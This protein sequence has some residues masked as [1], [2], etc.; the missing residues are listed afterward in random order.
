MSIAHSRLTS[1]GQVSVPSEVRKRLGIG[2]GSVVE[3][4]ES[5]GAIVVRRVGRFSVA[6]VR[7]ALF[8]GGAGRPRSLEELKDGVRASVKRRHARR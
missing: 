5:N 6:D 2:P 4:D 8:P 7:A 1:Q 3:W